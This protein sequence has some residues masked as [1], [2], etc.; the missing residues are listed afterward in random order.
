MSSHN[1]QNYT[2]LE[3]VR[4]LIKETKLGLLPCYSALKRFEDDYQQALDYLKSDKFKLRSR[5]KR[6]G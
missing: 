3:K 2:S 6:N 4:A 1:A 5:T